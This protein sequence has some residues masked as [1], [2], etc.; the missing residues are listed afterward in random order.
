MSEELEVMEGAGVDRRTFIKRSAVLGGM[1]WAAPAISTLGSRAFAATGTPRN[2]HAISYLAIVVTNGQTYQFKLQADGSV[3]TSNPMEAPQCDDPTGWNDP[4]NIGGFPAG[5]T[6][7]TSDE[8]CWSVTLPPG[9]TLTGVAMG[10]GGD[11]TTQGYCIDNPTIT[12]GGQK[13]TF[14]APEK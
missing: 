5:T 6:W 7:D 12:N 1:V 8:C 3:E 10:A 11:S 9:Y 2:C 13:Y 4:A 14:C